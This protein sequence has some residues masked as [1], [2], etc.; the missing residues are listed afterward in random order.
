MVSNHPCLNQHDAH[1]RVL[2]AMWV[3]SL[4]PSPPLLLISA[5]DLRKLTTAVSSLNELAIFVRRQTIL[6]NLDPIRAIVLVRQTR[7]D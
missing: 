2:T 3:T 6:L 4:Y 7:L 5:R 1:A